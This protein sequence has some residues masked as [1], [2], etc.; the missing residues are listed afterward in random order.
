VAAVTDRKGGRIRFADGSKRNVLKV[1]GN[2]KV[3]IQTRRID[4]FKRAKP[5]V[6]RQYGLEM[7]ATVD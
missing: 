3:G 1:A 7:F 2:E 5:P 6:M 4:I